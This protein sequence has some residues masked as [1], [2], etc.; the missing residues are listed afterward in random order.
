MFN[1]IKKLL[2]TDTPQEFITSSVFI[3][4]DEVDF[5]DFVEQVYDT[6][7]FEKW[8]N[9][10]P[11]VWLRFDKE[12]FDVGCTGII[13]FSMPPFYY[14]LTVVEITPDKSFELI[15]SGGMV[16]GTAKMKFS[17]VDGG[18]LLEDPHYLSGNNML[19]HKYYSILLAPG[20][21]PFMNWRYRILK[22][23]L[24]KETQRKRNN[25]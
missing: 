23:N 16:T 3:S 14:K 9:F 10:F 19:L 8:F 15:G 18:Y 4:S 12:R 25:N 2:S 5:D 6:R 1:W 17:K 20:H 24:A 21:V 11:I 22:R 13:R 7:K